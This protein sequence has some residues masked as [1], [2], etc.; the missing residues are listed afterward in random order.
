MRLS[1][2]ILVA[3]QFS[4]HLCLACVGPADLLVQVLACKQQWRTGRVCSKFAPSQYYTHLTRPLLDKNLKPRQ[5]F[6]SDSSRGFFRAWPMG[7]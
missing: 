5:L 7:E 1:K 4:K 2:K 3:D 6:R